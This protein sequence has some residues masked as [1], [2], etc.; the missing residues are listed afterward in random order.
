M[1]GA[2]VWALV[3]IIVENLKNLKGEKGHRVKLLLDA[4]DPLKSLY[5]SI[6]E[7]KIN[8]QTKSQELLVEAREIIHGLPNLT[9]PENWRNEQ[10]ELDFQ[11]GQM[12]QFGEIKG[13]CFSKHLY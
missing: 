8:A 4:K 13:C 12:R 11:M 9:V 10:F 2:K 3:A 7:N 5:K 1:A 6:L